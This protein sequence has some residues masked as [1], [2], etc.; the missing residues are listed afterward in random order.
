MKQGARWAVRRRWA[1]VILLFGCWT[2]LGL[3]FGSRLILSYGYS[4]QP[5]DW[6]L[7][8]LMSLSVWYGW[9]VLSPAIFWLAR[10]FSFESRRLW[11]NLAVHLFAGV[12]LSVIKVAL[13]GAVLPLVTGVAIRV[14]IAREL[15]PNLLTYWVLVGVLL[16][17][18]YYR[19]Y[20]ER[21]LRASQLEA[22][23]VQAQ[24]QV[25]KMQLHPHFLF[26]TLHA[27]STLMHRDVEAADR[28][29][30]RLSDLLRL[31]LETEGAQEVP[32]KQELEF[33]ERYVEIEKARFGDRLHVALDIQPDTLDAQVPYLIL[34]PL[35]ENAIRHGIA[36]RSAP[37]RIE[38]CAEHR[39]GLLRLQVRDDGAGLPEG[40]QDAV[41][42]GIGL[43]NTRA[44]LEQLYGAAH[45]F[46][47]RN[48]AEGGLE[49][50][51]SFPFRAETDGM[52][53]DRSENG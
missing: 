8:L 30:T 15:H 2:F 5:F 25:L 26:N 19:K 53:E 12:L 18:E 36:P 20:R 32:L 24:L 7:P 48:A 16:G 39:D 17:I 49:V 40:G 9:A 34:Q 51:L 46:E 35:V 37:G 28:M 21:E 10:R 11:R 3:F 29:L 23:L 45:R 42:S 44:R 43:A 38:I 27:I 50:S 13:D 41:N 6:K 1:R 47:L 14:N 52:T 22:R 31:T 33:L 4:G